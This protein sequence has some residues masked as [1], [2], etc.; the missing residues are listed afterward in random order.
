MR[1]LISFS[2]AAVHFSGVGDCD[3]NVIEFGIYTDSGGGGRWRLL[4]FITSRGK[5]R[6]VVE[7]SRM[8]DDC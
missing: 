1:E 4:E 7:L 8:V 3:I 2:R 6:L 5:L